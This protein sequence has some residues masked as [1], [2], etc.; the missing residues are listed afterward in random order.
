MRFVPLLAVVAAAG[1]ASA[2]AQDTASAPPQVYVAATVVRHV[3]PDL[4]VVTVRFSAVGPSPLEAGANV[5]ARA[6]SLRRAFQTLGIPRDSLI[7]GSQWYWWRGRVEAHPRAA[8]QRRLQTPNN[9]LCDMRYDTSYTVNDAIEIHIRDLS[10]AG[11][12][13]D[14]ALAHGITDISDISFR[15]DDT[16]AV[17]D[18][19]LAEATRRAR[20]QAEAIAAAAGATLGRIISL[21][22]Q[23]ESG[24]DPYYSLGVVTTSAGYN[25]GNGGTT[26]ISPSLP[27]SVTVYGK[28]ELVIK[29]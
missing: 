5:A 23:H 6:D 16:S 24:Y 15:A 8:C 2:A 17:Q 10:K 21:S 22:T 3:R 11:A 9:P 4:A 28:W 12:V 26:V 29:Q 1:S 20:R 18:E 14:T 7:N 19:A 13:I 27:V 25:A